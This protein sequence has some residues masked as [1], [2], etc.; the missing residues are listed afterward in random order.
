MR[1]L[2]RLAFVLSLSALLQ[3]SGCGGIG[4]DTPASNGAADVHA[5]LSNGAGPTNVAKLSWT[6]PTENTDGTPL[7]DLSGHKIYIRPAEG[8]YTELIDLSNP[9]LTTYVVD[10]LAPG[11]YFFVITAYN[12]AGRDSE[13]SSVVSKTINVPSNTPVS[14]P[15]VAAVIR[16][17]CETHRC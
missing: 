12:S 9:A 11:T 17:L 8:S 7:L 6:P 2:T 16:K 15:F 4:V 1:T 3:L 13:A 10:N 5:P 14:V